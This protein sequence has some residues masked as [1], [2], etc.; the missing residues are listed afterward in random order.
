MS[1]NTDTDAPWYPLYPLG[2]SSPFGLTKQLMPTRALAPLYICASILFENLYTKLG[3]FCSQT[4][5][6]CSVHWVILVPSG[7]AQDRFD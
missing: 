6:I 2:Q 7:I 4:L 5:R 1:L 3:E